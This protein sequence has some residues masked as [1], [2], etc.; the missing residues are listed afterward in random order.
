MG[1]PLRLDSIADLAAMAER[2]W[3]NRAELDLIRSELRHRSTAAAMKLSARVET[4]IGDCEDHVPPRNTNAPNGALSKN[5]QSASQDRKMPS[6]SQQTRDWT[7]EAVAKL[8]AKLIDLSRKSPLIAFKHTSRSAS[9]V[10]IVDERPDLLWEA[11]A[12]GTMG[13]EPLP[14][15][16]QTPKD[17]RTPQFGIAY[18]RARLTDEVFVAATEKLGD[19]ESDAR[20]WQD[21]ERALR[22]RVRAQLGLPKLDYG[23]GL[24]V[25]AIA[26]AHGFDSSFDLKSSDDDEVAAH[27]QDDRIR[28][29]LTQKELE[30]R[31]KSVADR[32]TSHLR[33]TGHHTLHLIFGFVQWYEDEASD[34]VSHAPL[35]LLP[36]T[37]EKD[38]NRARKEFRLGIWEGG[39]EVNVALIEKAREHW[40]LKIPAL[41]EDEAPESYFI[42]VKAVLDQ[43]QRLTLKRFVTLS[44]L[45]PM[46]LWRDLDP[47]RWPEDNFSEH[48]L[49]PG[50]IGATELRG[51]AGDDSIIDI[52]DP[53]QA[54]R[55]P[56]LITDA[57][58]SQHRAIMDMAAGHDMAIEGPPGTGKSQTITNM[59]AT[60]LSQGKRVLFVAE[61]QAALR[62][63]SARLRVAG[64]GPLLLELHGDKASRSEV[65]DGIRERLA[66]TPKQDARLLSEK[67]NELQRHRDLL[68]RYLS[69]V[70]TPLGRLANTA[71]HLAWRE[72]RLRG[73]FARD[74]V[75][76]MEARWTPER[77]L[78]LDH[79]ALQENRELL[80]QFG[81][82]LIALNAAE[83]GSE[84]TLWSLAERL[85]PF[86][87]SDALDA[88]ARAGRAAEAVILAAKPFKDLGIAFP[89]PDDDTID[90]L[91]AQISALAPLS[92]NDEAIVGSALHNRSASL[93]LIDQQR[94]WRKQLE[95]LRE[96][97]ENPDAVTAETTTALCDA[98]AIGHCPETPDEVVRE[99]LEYEALA[100]RL[101]AVARDIERVAPKFGDGAQT[102][103][104]TAVVIAGKIARLGEASPSVNALLANGLLD[105]VAGAVIAASARESAA[106]VAD[107]E[108]LLVSATPEALKTTPSELDD[109]AETVETTGVF[110][111]IF[112]GKYKAAKRRTT[113]LLNEQLDREETANVLRRTAGFGRANSLFSEQSKAR[114]LF[115]SMLWDGIDSDFA[116]ITAAHDLAAA[117]ASQLSAIDE[118][119]VLRWWLAADLPD[120]QRFSIVSREVV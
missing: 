57:D 5:D 90:T 83:V 59:I 62:V 32:A 87:Q 106:L 93:Q 86:D 54:L 66:T 44:V 10:R 50:L 98:L 82:A 1:R 74:T 91:T 12:N 92:C 51:V 76:A 41:R 40:G 101:A 103:I 64:F 24:D 111:R 21:A 96:E 72:I 89:E 28:V 19:N 7:Y 29:L 30:R 38:E 100:Q 65:Y 73:L 37:L 88:A 95:G 69:L 33:E 8:R 26:R 2:N 63:V 3:N 77:P 115:P 60:A 67:R 104:Q 34:L 17:E 49:L 75:K 48:R 9:Q 23:K 52:D 102:S 81:Q 55:V 27:H 108:G 71:H 118:V 53:A 25:A 46:V 112:G 58:A 70:R 79:P 14:G 43:G 97:V 105:P 13:F 61:K 80:A 4:W 120:R 16:D 20:A 42:R 47:E 22:S 94:T 114:S 11:L 109:L 6:V 116:S 99:R 39:L 117:Q 110:G 119:E 113:R 56:A 15:E 35:L 45:P 78:E 36:V 68:R 107:R 85:D 31:L 18:E 84:R